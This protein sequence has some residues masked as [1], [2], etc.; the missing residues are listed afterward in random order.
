MLAQRWREMS[1]KQPDIAL[2]LSDVGLSPKI[3]CNQ[4]QHAFMLY[5][6]QMHNLTL[7][8]RYKAIALSFFVKMSHMEKRQVR[9]CFTKRLRVYKM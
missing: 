9:L 6:I 8:D 1:I 3:T 5:L 2:N 7:F 4:K